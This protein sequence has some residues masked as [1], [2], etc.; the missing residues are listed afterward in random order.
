MMI[1]IRVRRIVAALAAVTA[2]VVV[3]PQHAV[4]NTPPTGLPDAHVV[5]TSTA[6]NYAFTTTTSEWSIV[7]VATTADYDLNLYQNGVLLGTSAAGTGI[8]DFI[9]INN[10][11]RPLGTYTASVIHYAGTGLYYVEQRQGHTEYCDARARQ[12]RRHRT[13]RSRPAVLLGEERRT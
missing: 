9:A 5:S 8:T 1:K 4:A 7:G 12:R 3:A 11:L 13:L 6:V 2:I 10:H